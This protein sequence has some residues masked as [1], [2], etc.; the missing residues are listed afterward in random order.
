[1]AEGGTAYARDLS[2][3][4]T[5]DPPPICFTVA[6]SI[7]YKLRLQNDPNSGPPD[8]AHCMRCDTDCPRVSGTTFQDMKF[9]CVNPECSTR[10]GI[11]MRIQAYSTVQMFKDE[12]MP[13]LGSLSKEIGLLI[14][15]QA[16][17][18]NI[19]NNTQRANAGIL[20]LR[21]VAIPES[22]DSIPCEEVE[23]QEFIGDLFFNRFSKIEGS[24]QYLLYLIERAQE[25]KVPKVEELTTVSLN[26]KTDLADNTM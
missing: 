10:R 14:T 24:L 20:E 23:L 4:E 18:Q 15:L 16:R 11:N 6:Q 26:D 9:E 25:Y 13:M 22:D 5:F 12:N 21:G 19:I 17:L 1:M 7:A 8:Y 2:V 3:V